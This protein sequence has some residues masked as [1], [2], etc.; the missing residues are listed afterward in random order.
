MLGSLLS[1]IDGIFVWPNIPVE[2]AVLCETIHFTLATFS[3]L[4]AYFLTS[5][6]VSSAWPGKYTYRSPYWSGVFCAVLS[7]WI[8]DIHAM[9][10]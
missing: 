8:I 7:H 3:G 4:G 1:W 6:T 9:G 2:Y 5:I 10:A